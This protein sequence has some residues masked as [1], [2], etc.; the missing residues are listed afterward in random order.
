MKKLLALLLA[1]ILPCCALADSFSVDWSMEVTPE[2]LS[3]LLDKVADNLFG[4]IPPVSDS[5]MEALAGL[6]SSFTIS[7]TTDISGTR[8][9]F[10]LLCQEQTI[11]SVDASFTDDSTLYACDLLPDALLSL[12]GDITMLHERQQ[13]REAL[14]KLDQQAVSGTL[15]DCI[16]A[17]AAML[18]QTQE[19]G[20]FAGETYAG[21]TRCATYRFDD[22]DLTLLAELLSR[23]KW[24]EEAVTA[25]ENYILVSHE[26]PDALRSALFDR[27]YYAAYVNQYH[28][29]LR[30]V[31]DDAQM[32]GLSLLAYDQDTLVSTLSVGFS[33]DRI[34]AV[35]GYGIHDQNAYLSMDFS[36][37]DQ[38]R[39]ILTA[40]FWR[41]PF[42]SG[43][44]TASS[45][46]ANLLL[47][48]DAE[49]VGDD[50]IRALTITLS[51][52]TL[53]NS[54][55]VMKLTGTND[56]FAVDVALD[57]LPLMS[58][59]MTYAA[60]DDLPAMDA[61]SSQ[62]FSLD[63]M[64]DDEWTQLFD[65]FDGLRTQLIVRLFKATPPELL[66][67]TLMPFNLFD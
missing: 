60:T 49:F 43:Y 37:S 56:S 27:L 35:L 3:A 42:R 36:A 19:S 61:D 1:L 32:I 5:L 9:R 59:R 45:D 11:L 66:T 54:C 7:S 13:V 39:P 28:Y 65:L 33:D 10:V 2:G 48:V 6:L 12:P 67:L 50:A 62:V 15:S 17:W 47:S 30:L 46:P 25:L 24:P 55:I 29:V 23:S 41:D 22:R 64:S 26:D 40:R 63:D 4:E 58:S 18:E 44:Y 53:W 20:S 51:G 16:S 34:R 8:Q 52:S 31:S 57:D 21:G 38:G 14:E